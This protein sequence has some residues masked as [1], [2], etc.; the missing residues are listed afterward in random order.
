VQYAETRDAIARVLDEPQQRKDVLDVCGVEKL[1][2]AEF[3][4]RDV[5]AGEFDLQR[6][7]VRGCAE[8]DRLLLEKRSF[9]AVFKDPLDDVPR[10][11]RLVPDGD[12]PR[13][14]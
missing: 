13:F 2:A 9:L 5:A 12:Q 11:V 3:H 7:T 10:L 4:E 14:C 1:E 8:E 6:P